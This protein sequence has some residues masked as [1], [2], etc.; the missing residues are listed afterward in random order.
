MRGS[1]FY[2]SASRT[3]SPKRD[4]LFTAAS[5]FIPG[6]CTVV[7]TH[8]KFPFEYEGN[9]SYSCIKFPPKVG[10]EYDDGDGDSAS[11]DDDWYC[12][13]D[14]GGKEAWGKCNDG[15]FDDEG[16]SKNDFWFLRTYHET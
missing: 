16:T 14:V 2:A 6:N 8:C 3:S 12:K 4:H 15:C 11:N 5:F 9:S 13:V 10:P 1:S 7:P